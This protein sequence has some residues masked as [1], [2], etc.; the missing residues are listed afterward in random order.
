VATDG[1]AFGPDVMDE[2]VRSRRAFLRTVSMVAAAVPVLVEARR[3]MVGPQVVEAAV[4]D[5]DT[6]RMRMLADWTAL[7]F[8]TPHPTVYGAAIF[9]TASGEELM[10]ALNAV[11][12]QHDPSAHGEIVTIRLA[13]TKLGKPSL[14]GYTLYTTCEP[15]PMCMAC[16]LWAGLDRVVFGA[17]IDDAARFG[18]QIMIYSAD[19]KAHWKGACVVDGP[20]DRERCAALFSDPKLLAAR[21]KRKPT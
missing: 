21:E 14:K 19:V 4:S 3:A 18:S 7:S 16:C 10:R 11:G 17:T 8:D 12:A 6:Q 1:S 5:V 15:C 9:D 20:V 13:C 2:R